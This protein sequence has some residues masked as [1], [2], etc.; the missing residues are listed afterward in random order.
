M[1]SSTQ[2]SDPTDDRLVR[3]PEPRAVP[4]LQSDKDMSIK[5]YI[6]PT[7]YSI[8]ALCHNSIGSWFQQLKCDKQISNH[9]LYGFYS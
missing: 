2:E 6:V 3:I 8:A 5:Y 7:S 1:G 9:K 4:S